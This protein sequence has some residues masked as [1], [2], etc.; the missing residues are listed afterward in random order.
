MKNKLVEYKGY[1]AS[2]NVSIEDGC[3]YGKVEFIN[4]S[5]VFGAGTVQELTKQFEIEI[6]DYLA[7]CKEVGKDPDKTIK[8]TFNVR[9]GAELHREALLKSTN[10]GCSLNDVVK[11]S[12]QLY[13]C[14]S[15]EVHNH[16]SVSIHKHHELPKEST[17]IIKDFD[18]SPSSDFIWQP[19]V[20]GATADV[21]AH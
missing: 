14:E 7:F 17:V 19:D 16:V 9:V 1:Y 2:I 6:D 11:K 10:D 18:T 8:G 5:I 12:M 3:L 20:T 21:K 15:N 4:D 13:L